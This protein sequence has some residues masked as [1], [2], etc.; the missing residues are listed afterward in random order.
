MSV[1]PSNT[2][3][4]S[5]RANAVSAFFNKL[6]VQLPSSGISYIEQL[7]NSFF[8]TLYSWCDS[9]VRCQIW[10]S[11]TAVTETLPSL[12]NRILLDSQHKRDLC[13]CIWRKKSDYLFFSKWSSSRCCQCS[14]HDS[15]SVSFLRILNDTGLEVQKAS[16]KIETTL[17]S[18][19]SK[20]KTKM[21]KHSRLL[22]TLL[23]KQ[24]L[25]SCTRCIYTR[26]RM[27]ID[28]LLYYCRVNSSSIRVLNKLFNANVFI[29]IFLE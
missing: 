8:Q 10:K 18:E 12:S 29:F 17:P 1:F 6:L 15:I 7:T 23:L 3:G 22:W 19:S 2:K 11:S 21:G 9:W 4:N 24:I 16:R 14:S 5:F 13:W 28:Y 27:D 26:N 25:I 20:R